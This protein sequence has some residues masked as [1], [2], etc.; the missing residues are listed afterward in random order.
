MKPRNRVSNPT[1]E[2]IQAFIRDAELRVRP[3]VLSGEL[4][5]GYIQGFKYKRITAFLFQ[6]RHGFLHRHVVEFELQ[7]LSPTTY[8]DSEHH[9]QNKHFSF[10]VHKERNFFGF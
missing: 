5:K 8:S 7:T 10:A 2:H 9:A 3:F 4:S 6:F 1:L